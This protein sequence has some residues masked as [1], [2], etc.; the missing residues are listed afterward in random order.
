MKLRERKL[1]RKND[2]ASSFRKKPQLKPK[3][4]ET[5]LIV[6]KLQDKQLSN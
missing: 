4:P 3:R 5:E 1:R 6:R 2:S